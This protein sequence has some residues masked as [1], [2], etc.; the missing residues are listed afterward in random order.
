[1]TIGSVNG[2]VDILENHQ[3]SPKNKLLIWKDERYTIPEEMKED[4]I[5]KLEEMSQPYC[6]YSA[7]VIDL[8]SR[9]PDLYSVLSYWYGDVVTT[10]SRRSGTRIKQRIVKLT[11]Y[12]HEPEKNSC[13]ISNTKLDFVEIQKEAEEATDALTSALGTDGSI[14]AEAIEEAQNSTDG[15]STATTD[16]VDIDG[17]DA[18]EDDVITIDGGD[19]YN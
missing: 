4:A 7:D 12:M 11:V 14:S 19:A 15:G 10:A 1:M 13:E 16:T 6:S 9:Y 2:G 5:Y 8:A 3:Y 18:V 17:G